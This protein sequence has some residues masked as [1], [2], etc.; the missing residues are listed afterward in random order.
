MKIQH[1]LIPLDM[2]SLAEAAL[3]YARSVVGMDGQITLLYVVEPAAA[4][5][6]STIGA[7]TPGIAPVQTVA[8]SVAPYQ[9]FDSLQA[10][11]ENA[12]LYLERTAERLRSP[13]RTINYLIKDGQ[14]AEQI[15]AAAEELKV[16]AI[17]MATHGRSGISRLVL[18]SVANK[19]VSE[20]RCPVF[21]I[22][23]KAL[24]SYNAH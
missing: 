14:A 7:A 19:V 18:G 15:L 8:T 9:S 6:K 21:L 23:Q 24:R 11:W 16:D 5:S 17:I 3:D 13:H 2:S 12:R 1:V 4:V 10:A 22:P 20:A